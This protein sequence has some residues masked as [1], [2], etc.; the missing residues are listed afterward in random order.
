MEGK[1]AE[2]ALDAAS[3]IMEKKNDEAQDLSLYD[4]F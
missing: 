3:K 1:V 2:L 4:Q